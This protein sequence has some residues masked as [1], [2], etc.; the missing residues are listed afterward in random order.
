[1]PWC[2]ANRLANGENMFGL[3][4]LHSSGDRNSLLS[5]L[6][7][8]WSDFFTLLLSGW[9]DRASLFFLAVDSF[10][11]EDIMELVR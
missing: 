6:S 8:Y 3:E 10:S 9:G 4:L 11:A 5:F 7:S 2:L 1:M